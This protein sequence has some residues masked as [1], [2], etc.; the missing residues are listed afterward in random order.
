MGFGPYCLNCH[1]SAGNHLTFSAASNI[2]GQPGDPITYLTQ[3]FNSLQRFDDPRANNATSSKASKTGADKE[4]ASHHQAVLSIG[5]SQSVPLQISEK[6]SADTVTGLGLID[7]SII[8][9][10]DQESIT[11][12]SQTYDNVWMK[13]GEV[14][15]HGQYLTSDQCL[16]CHDA[17]STGMQFD[18]ATKD[19]EGSGTLLNFSPYA[20]WRTSPMGLAGRDPIFFHKWRV[21]CRPF[22]KTP[23]IL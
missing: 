5:E 10:V 1:A 20:T 9:D 4:D 16:G 21:R 14:N 15:Y 22:T 3:D 11:M 23:G 19:P 8:G 2:A 13:A 17:G 12:P 7:P 18:M 6:S